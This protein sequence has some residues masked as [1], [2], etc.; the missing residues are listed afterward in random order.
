MQDHVQEYYMYIHSYRI[1]RPEA[2][3][4][5]GANIHQHSR[6]H[7][8]VERGKTTCILKIDQLAEKFVDNAGLRKSF[9]SPPRCDRK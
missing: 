4:K 1:E 2:V 8:H 5:L 6:V 3:G 9:I 7:V